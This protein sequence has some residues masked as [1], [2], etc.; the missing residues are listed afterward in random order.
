[1]ISLRS[2]PNESVSL[3]TMT[4]L[5]DFVRQRRIDL[6]YPTQT[7]FAEAAGIHS[8]HLNQIER[9]KI[10]LPNADLRRRLAKGLGISHIELL[11][12]AGELESKEVEAAGVQGVVDRPSYD[13]LMPFLDAI[14]W[15]PGWL[16][17]EKAH[18]K[19]LAKAQ[20]GEVDE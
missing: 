17:M 15:T 1:M 5:G 4:T 12:A 9:G 16:E 2:I 19:W 3:V 11:V 20:R 8:A 7:G 14:Q 6:G 13:E 10:A 18:L